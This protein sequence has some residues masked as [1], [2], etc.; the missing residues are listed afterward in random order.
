MRRPTGRDTL[1][2]RRRRPGVVLIYVSVFLVMLL[3]FVALAVDMGRVQSARTELGATADG[4][5]RASVWLVPT[6]NFTAAQDRA[7]SLASRN[8]ADGT[9]VTLDRTL[10]IEF[11]VWRRTTGTFTVLTG[12]ARAGANA[13]RVTPRRTSG[14]GN[15]ISLSFA[16]VLNRTTMDVQASAVAMIRGG[17]STQGHGL[18]IVGIN[19]ISLNGTTTTDSYNATTGAYGAGTAHPGGS[20]ASNGS[21]SLVGTVDINGDARPGPDVGDTLSV[22]SNSDISGWRAPLDAELLYPPATLGSYNNTPIAASLDKTGSFNVSGKQTV[23]IPGGTYYVQDLTL[24]SNQTIS[25]QGPVKIYVNGNVDLTGSITVNQGL[26][27]NFEIVV[28]GSGT[29][30]LGGGSQLYAHVY[31]PLSDVTIHGTQDSFGL[32]GTVIGKTLSIL[33]NSAIHYDESAA[34]PGTALPGQFWVE[35]VQ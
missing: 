5:A 25:V 6:L 24:K 9:S 12:T 21:I 2:R 13:V 27:A 22:N 32:F 15:P 30:N 26:P 33:G 3:A 19:S 14:R 4:S 10:D 29:V 28:L 20:I 8:K 18:G 34:Y 16:A 11:G 7:I 23:S 31:A 17:Y 1:G 35:L